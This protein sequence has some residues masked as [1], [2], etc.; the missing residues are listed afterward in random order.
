MTPPA[1]MGWSL[2]LREVQPGV[3]KVSRI[4]PGRVANGGR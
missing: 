4:T 3:W 2:G 1:G